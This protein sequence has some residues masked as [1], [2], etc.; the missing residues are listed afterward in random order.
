[1][2][3][4]D[5]NVGYAATS[6]HGILPA[7]INASSWSDLEPIK[8]FQVAHGLPP[9][10]KFGP[11]AVAAFRAGHPATALP[12]FG[13]T[14]AFTARHTKPRP[15][16]P[17]AIV[18]HDT[19]SHTAIG[20]QR[21]LDDH[22]YATHF[23]IELDGTVYQC[24]DP[25]TTYGAHCGGF[26]AESIGIDVVAILDPTYANTAE[27][28]RLAARPWSASKVKGQVIDYT[29]AQ[30]VALV[31]LVDQLC[32]AFGIPRVVPHELTG[33]GRKVAGLT[34][35]YRG[36]LAHGQWS[37]SRWDGLPAVEAIV[38]AGYQNGAPS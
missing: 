2:T 20:A 4:L 1:M 5:F 27:R 28:L 24:M 33:Y 8:A 37:R 17:T 32:A 25:A 21:T 3:P 23:L 31:H 12:S 36:V 14:G 15:S 29:Q 22:G 6:K 35:K 19:V 34:D 9:D 10:G 16:P 7:D 11:R 38:A 30:K 18:I 26:N 13:R